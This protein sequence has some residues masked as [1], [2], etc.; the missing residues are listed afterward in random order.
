VKQ[1][2]RALGWLSKLIWIVTI[3]LPVTFG[4]SMGKLFQPDTIGFGEATT[5]FVNSRIRISLPFYIN[6]TGY[7]DISNVNVTTVLKNSEG[8]NAVEGETLIPAI[9]AGSKVNASHEIEVILDELTGEMEY[10][11]FND[12]MLNLNV[13][14]SLKFAYIL[15]VSLHT[16]LTIP[17]GAPLHNLTI[18]RITFDQSTG[19]LIIHVT[20]ENH[21]PLTID[22]TLQ[23]MVYNNADEV[24]GN[25][26]VPVEAVPGDLFLSEIPIE[27]DLSKLTNNGYVLLFFRSKEFSAGPTKRE[28]SL[29]E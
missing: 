7:Y 15:G 22:G 27:I 16:N 26:S 12:T 13:S 29:H 6:N 8:K 1:V 28:W 11:F 5:S 3:L 10:L 21:S 4:L 24:I 9:R 17:W 20:F 19:K 14:F 2:I 23:I 25:Q 18:Y